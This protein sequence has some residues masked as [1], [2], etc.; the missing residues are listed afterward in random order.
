MI[1]K[2]YPNDEEL[3]DK[4]FN[5]HEQSQINK[6]VFKSTSHIC[7]ASIKK[8]TS[9]G[10][11]DSKMRT[12]MSFKSSIGL[13]RIMTSRGFNQ[14]GF[15]GFNT[16]M[17]KTGGKFKLEPLRENKGV[18]CEEENNKN[19]IEKNDCNNANVILEEKRKVTFPNEEMQINENSKEES[20]SNENKVSEKE[21]DMNNEN[22]ENDNNENEE[23]DR[24]ENENIQN[25]ENEQNEQN[26]NN[27]NENNENDKNENNE[28]ENNDK[29]DKNENEENLNEENLNEENLFNTKEKFKADLKDNKYKINNT[30]YTHH[31]NTNSNINMNTMNLT[32]QENKFIIPV[33]E[34]L[35]E[36]YSFNNIFDDKVKKKIF[37]KDI[38]KKINL[39]KIKLNKE[40]LKI[41]K[42]EKIKENQRNILYSKTTSVVEK[43]NLESIIALERVQS[44][45]KILRLNE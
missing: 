16:N 5:L 39:H 45:E 35:N 40:I 13:S 14:T 37:E 15:S 24:N 26:N 44:S 36:I 25:N 4:Y 30:N 6:D 12:N 17:N 10:L 34:N 23:N 20:F 22:E 18:I 11:N 33:R 19:N 21:C 9:V 31:T 43:K 29:N 1:K 27:E 2:L 7:N 32:K 42:E 38:E 28:N 41:L 3:L 8:I